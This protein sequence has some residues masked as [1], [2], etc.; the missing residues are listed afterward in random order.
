MSSSWSQILRRERLRELAGDGPFHR[1]EQYSA[2]GMVGPPIIANQR[3]TA[4]VVG[5][6]RYDV[7]LSVSDLQ[8]R[9]SCDCPVGQRGDFCKHAVALG[10]TLITST[11]QGDEHLAM[12]TDD[13]RSCLAGLDREALI[14]MLVAAA[15][16][17]LVIRERIHL[18]VARSKGHALDLAHLS[19]YLQRA[20]ETSLAVDV[21]ASNEHWLR[22]AEELLAVLLEE[23]AAGEAAELVEAAV[24]Q[25]AEVVHEGRGAP[26][27]LALLRAWLRRLHMMVCS[28]AQGAPEA[29]AQRVFDLQRRTGNAIGARVERDYSGALGERGL[30]IYRRLVL[31]HWAHSIQSANPS[32]ETWMIRIVERWAAQEGGLAARVDVLRAIAP[33]AVISRRIA[34]LYQREGLDEAAIEWAERAIHLMPELAE[35]E[36]FDLLLSSYARRGEVDKTL[37][38]LGARLKV[39]PDPERYRECEQLA[40]AH[41]WGEQWRERALAILSCVPGSDRSMVVS[42]LLAIGNVDDAW[43]EASEGGC[44]DELWVELARRRERA[45][46]EEAL[47][48]Y[49]RQVERCLGRKNNYAYEEAIGLMRGIRRLQR[50]LG[51]A[52]DFAAYLD[53]VRAGHRGQRNF[54]NLLDRAFARLARPGGSK[55]SGAKR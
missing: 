34:R 40:S 41:G 3:I 10:L 18:R 44:A 4:C 27:R 5:T 17:P 28:Q 37:D 43:R 38:L 20:L 35:G 53:E 46:P 51:R 11:E 30:A 42:L 16:E 25:F 48:I 54:I 31:D 49:R 6:R 32:P 7:S 23:G 29:L 21:E 36:I 19:R 55:R 52:E 14:N 39:R 12:T 1:G 24:E 47:R 26:A 2:W 13:I 45:D 9:S 22:C 8:L 15:L 50:R 33:N